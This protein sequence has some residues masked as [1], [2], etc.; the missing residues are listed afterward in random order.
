MQWQVKL[1]GKSFIVALPEPLPDGAPF[2]L[3]VDGAPW[4]AAFREA[5]GLLVLTDAKGVEHNHKLRARRY[6]R[7][8]GESQATV[9]LELR[10]PGG[11]G[12]WNAT[13]E[14][15]VPG[16]DQRRG[17]KADQGQ[18]VRSQITGKVLKVFVKPGD[19]V[20]GGQVLLLVEAMKMENRIFA[21]RAGT[22]QSVAV[23]DGDAVATGKELVRLT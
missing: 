20:E 12:N 10:A 8:D 3:T 21:A 1:N 9:A 19:K 2:P 11:V 4:T 18:I 14:P 6:E 23:K 13:L 22:V 15:H 5:E 17:A 7:F 16:Q